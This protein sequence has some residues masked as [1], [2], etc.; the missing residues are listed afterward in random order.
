M[1]IGL[2]SISLAGLVFWAENSINQLGTEQKQQVES[3]TKDVILNNPE[4]IIKSLQDYDQKRAESALDKRVQLA[5]A[6]KDQL[7]ASADDPFEGDINGKTIIAEFLDYQCGY[8][9]RMHG[10]IQSFLNKNPKG[11]KVVYKVIPVLG[12]RSKQAAITSMSG[13]KIGKFKELHTQ[14]ME[15]GRITDEHIAKIA[16]DNEL[17]EDL[18]RMGE[19]QLA[20]NINLMD[21]LG[22]EST[23]VMYISKPNGTIKIIPGYVDYDDFDAAVK[24]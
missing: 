17:T 2:L 8:C 6:N 1:R 7:F 20:K 14:L 5:L 3:I 21:R 16:K 11:Y 13:V 9:K 23:P 10:V 24:E 22:V 19:L 18:K 4:I 12:E 15:S